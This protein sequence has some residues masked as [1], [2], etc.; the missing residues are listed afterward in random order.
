MISPCGGFQRDPVF[1]S[2]SRSSSGCLPMQQQAPEVLHEGP[3]SPGPQDSFPDGTLKISQG[4]CVSSS[5]SQSQVS[6]KTHNGRYG[7]IAEQ[8]SVPFVGIAQQFWAS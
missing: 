7:I 4:L 8:A 5:S 3:V 6:T 2:Q 1:W